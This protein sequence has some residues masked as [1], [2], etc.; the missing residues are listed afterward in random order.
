MRPLEPR[1]LNSLRLQGRA[2]RRPVAASMP[3]LDGYVAAIAAGPVSISPLVWICSL[4][5]IDAGAF[6]H[7]GTA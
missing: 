6:D 3:V 2:E 7:G 5:A 1:T 4:L